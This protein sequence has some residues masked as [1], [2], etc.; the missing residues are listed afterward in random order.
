MLWPILENDDDDVN[1]NM[2]TALGGLR[3]LEEDEDEADTREADE[4]EDDV[5]MNTVHDEIAYACFMAQRRR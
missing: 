3:M 1:F 5:N 4:V 2:A